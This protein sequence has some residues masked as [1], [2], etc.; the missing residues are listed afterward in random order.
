MT[1]G[2]RIQKLEPRERQLLTGLGVVVGAMIFLILPVVL[3]KSVA[4]ARDENQAIRDYLATVRESRDMVDKRRA[5]YDAMLG[6]YQKP[7]PA[8]AAFAED[9]A[10]TYEVDIAESQARPDVPHGKKYVEHIL[11][12]RLKKTGL[13]G[14]AHMMEKIEKSGLPLSITKLNI[15]PRAG[16]A[17]SYD[18]EMHLSAFERKGTEKKV[19]AERP[20]EEEEEQ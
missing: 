16:E 12:L 19:E 7:M 20:P 9:A 5:A 10:R 2:E 8:L 3:Y 4:S 15:K 1:L 13:A 18:V 11:S 6:R 17:D 14:L